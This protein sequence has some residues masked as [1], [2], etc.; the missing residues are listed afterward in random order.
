MHSRCCAGSSTGARSS[1][2]GASSAATLQ[3]VV[4]ARGKAEPLRIEADEGVHHYS[5]ES[6]ASLKPVNEGGVVTFG[7]QT[8]PA[9]GA[10]GVVVARAERIRGSAS[11]RVLAIDFAR[12]EK[13]EMP[14]AAT[15][16]ALKRSIKRACGWTTCVSW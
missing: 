3:P 1:T 10:P 13:A 4:V 11:A 8:H 16:A 15:T 9:D 7:S 5:A 12:A 2:T 14:K 6:L